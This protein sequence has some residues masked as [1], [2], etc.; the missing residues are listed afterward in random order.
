MISSQNLTAVWQHGETPADCSKLRAEV[1]LEEQGFSYD[2][3]DT[4]AVCYHLCVY[5]DGQ[6][7][8]VA[9]MFREN[10]ST[11][12]IGR[13]AVKKNLRGQHIGR[14]IITNLEEKA[15]ELGAGYLELGA[16]LHAIPFY[17]TCGFSKYGELFDDDGAPHCHMKKQIG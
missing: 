9:R 1:F 8:G 13:I 7:V 10:E 14:F 11:M 4:D 16:Q 12:H 2:K 15:K 17:E 5:R 3:D 6:A